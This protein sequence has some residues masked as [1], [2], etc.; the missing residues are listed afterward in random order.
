M[1]GGR[2]PAPVDMVNI[3][4][5]TMFHTSQVVR[6]LFHHQY[7]IKNSC[8]FPSKHNPSQDLPEFAQKEHGFMVISPVLSHAVN[9]QDQHNNNKTS[10]I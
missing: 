2:N 8:T 1:V 10:V 6:D 3:S 4:L 9:G 5:F 7:C